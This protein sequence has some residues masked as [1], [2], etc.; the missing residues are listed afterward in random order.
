MKL[1][2]TNCY[3][4]AITFYFSLSWPTHSLKH[5]FSSHS[6]HSILFLACL[7]H[8]VWQHAPVGQVPVLCCP[9]SWHLCTPIPVACPW[10][11][12]VLGLVKHSLCMKCHL[13]DDISAV[14]YRKARG[15]FEAR[16]PLKAPPSTLLLY[17]SPLWHSF[18]FLPAVCLPSPFANLNVTVFLSFLY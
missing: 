4:S 7:Q 12:V 1:L 16:W 17:S 14:S 5:L 15:R 8:L 3:S 2:V 13:P 10:P 6:S 9:D 18:C 11:F